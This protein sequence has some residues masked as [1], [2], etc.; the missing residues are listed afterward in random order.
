M[1]T[2]LLSLVGLVGAAF[3]LGGCPATTGTTTPANKPAATGARGGTETTVGDAD[4]GKKVDL[5]VGETLT[6]RLEANATTG[7][8]WRTK[9]R[10]GE[11]LTVV[12][13]QPEYVADPA[14]P[15]VV[16]SGGHALFRYKAVKPGTESLGF[17]YIRPIQPD[18]VAKE[19]KFQVVVVK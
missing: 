5:H 10:K 19:A 3:C 6:V 13:K 4:V 12:G 18:K 1:K 7:Y 16:G 14:K 15:G 11:S 2:R 8:G 17:I 9:Q